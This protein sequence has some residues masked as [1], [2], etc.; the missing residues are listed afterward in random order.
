MPGGRIQDRSRGSHGKRKWIP[1]SCKSG[2]PIATTCNALED[3]EERYRR[4]YL[5]TILNPEVKERLTM[6][7]RIISSLREFLDKKDFV[8][9]ETPTLQPIYGG[10]S[11]GFFLRITTLLT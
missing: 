8:E 6:R 5:D 9:V 2:S 7:S 4:R 3:I 10:D 1:I 11:G